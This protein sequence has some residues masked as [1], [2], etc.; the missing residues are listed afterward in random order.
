MKRK[1]KKKQSL[2]LTITIL[3]I[4]YH[5]ADITVSS[6]TSKEQ[7]DNPSLAIQKPMSTSEKIDFSLA[8][9]AMQTISGKQAL[10]HVKFLA[11]E[12]MQGRDT[13]SQ[14]Q[15][16]AARYIACEFE[17]Y[18]LKP[19]AD[20]GTYYQNISALYSKV[21]KP[22]DLSIEGKVYTEDKDYETCAIGSA[23]VTAPAVFAGYGI[24]LDDYDDYS[25]LDAKGK[26]VVVMAGKPVLG[27][28]SKEMRW[29]V[30]AVHEV[31]VANAIARG[32][33][34]MLLIKETAPK[35]NRKIPIGKE[36]TIQENMQL[37]ASMGPKLGLSS[38]ITDKASM[39]Q[40]SVSSFPM[41]Y[42]SLEVANELLSGSKKTLSDLQENPH[43]FQLYKKVTLKITVDIAQRK[44]M[45]VI[46][47]LEG[48]D[49]LLKKEVII[50]GAHY[51]ALGIDEKGKA[52]NGADDNA[53]GVA[54][55][56]EVARA[57]ATGSLKPKR[58]LLFIAF[59]GEEKG[60]SGSRYY[61]AFLKY[62]VT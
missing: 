33:V 50:I 26:I 12:E 55:L 9:S 56:L 14:E 20:D 42:I 11:S 61:L 3:F 17:K 4:S 62:D 10:F 47:L 5:A 57:F 18:G 37:L 40:T 30:A 51:D 48:S 28:K 24:T 29:D 25:D 46:G 36:G 43:S 53:S 34:G 54:A 52:F 59:T 16:I 27:I 6:A 38:E 13:F 21:G 32:A 19:I 60:A 44:T 31:R 39:I 1:R 8:L 41:V 45:N 49:L 35:W 7:Q 58:S 2:V 15:F 23:D 22:N